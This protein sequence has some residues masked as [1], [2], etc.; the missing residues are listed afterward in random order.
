MYK[1]CC[2]SMAMRLY[3][4]IRSLLVHPKDKVSKEDRVQ[5]V[6]LQYLLHIKTARKSTLERWDVVL[7]SARRNNRRKWNYTKVR[8][9]SEAPGNNHSQSRTS[10]HS[11]TIVN[12]E[13]HI[14]D[15][16]AAAIIGQ[17]SDRATRWIREVVKIRQEAQVVMNRDEGVFL[18]SH[19][20]DD[21]LL[22]TAA[23]AATF[24]FEKGNCRC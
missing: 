16:E 19:V 10:L 3:T 17:E 24:Q 12:T 7:E 14:I 8:N 6:R 4:T 2:I 15:C 5:R 21:L 22:S 18:L 1:R 23:T 9:T 11:Q 13:N 20:Y